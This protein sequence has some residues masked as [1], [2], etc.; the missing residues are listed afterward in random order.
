MW[1][2]FMKLLCVSPVPQV[3][4]AQQ[5]EAAVP[6]AAGER[7]VVAKKAAHSSYTTCT[8]PC[9][10]E[11]IV[12][13]ALAHVVGWALKFAINT[14]SPSESVNSS[15]ETFPYPGHPAEHSVVHP[16]FHGDNQ[17]GLPDTHAST[18][19]YAYAHATVP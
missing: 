18:Y 2:E 5:A 16:V 10:E 8:H 1:F 7:G 3:H 11:S 13:L 4:F 14:T 12:S 19:D 6:S 15:C 9:P 17:R